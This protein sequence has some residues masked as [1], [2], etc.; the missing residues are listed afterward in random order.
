VATT[1]A[2]LEAILGADTRGFDRAM[3]S[4]QSRMKSMGKAAALGGL[5]IA[6]GIAVGLKKSADAAI[7][8][9]T[10]QAR[11]PGSVRTST[12][13]RFRRTSRRHRGWLRS[14]MKT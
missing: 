14:T 1:V 5:A 3:D 11:L 13:P 8:A 9:E 12:A 10:A 2:R 4:S 7:E 6:G